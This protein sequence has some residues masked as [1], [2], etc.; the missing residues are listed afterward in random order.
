[1]E[2]TEKNSPVKRVMQF[3]FKPTYACNLAC[4]YCHIHRLR[5]ADQEVI[6][7]HQAS[8][9]FNW[10]ADYADMHNANVVDILWHGGEPLQVPFDD[11]S[12]ILADYNETF[13]KKG[14]ECSSSIQTNLLML[15]MQKLELI[16]KYFNSV[17]GF[18][19][20]CF[21][22]ER[23]FPNGKDA[24][25][26]IWQKALWAKE[27]GVNIGCITQVTAKNVD[28]IDKIYEWFRNSGISFKFSRTRDTDEYATTL[29]DEKYSEAI[30]RLF[31]IWIEDIPQKISISNFVEYIQML[32]SGR[33]SS[34]CYQP[35]CNLLS[36]TG[37]G[38]ILFCDRDDAGNLVG[39]YLKDTP[40]EVDKRIA[41]LRVRLGMAKDTICHQC[42]YMH[43]CNGGCPM[44]HM[45]GWASR[46]CNTL[47]SILDHISSY[48]LSHNYELFA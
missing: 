48:L 34:C 26:R 14:I 17:V 6:K 12:I 27:Q 23:C 46:E 31:D 20:D 37:N 9:L 41:Q 2:H 40:S 42:R 22:D 13:A 16:K 29:S 5:D 30:K 38:N 18:S 15:D 7:P 39:N 8:T 47:Q 10:I 45:S 44:N 24:S 1:M 25:S 19:Y 28:K 35:E 3:M 11:M 36:F 32:L 4:R 33:S 21:V 43:I